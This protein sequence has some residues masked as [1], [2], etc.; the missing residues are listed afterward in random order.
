MWLGCQVKYLL[1]KT[2]FLVYKQK[3]PKTIRVK[4]IWPTKTILKKKRVIS[5]NKNLGYY[6]KCRSL[7]FDTVVMEGEKDDNAQKKKR[8][9]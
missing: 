5:I 1:P 7:N 9:R 3:I 8:D 2:S 4:S 6:I